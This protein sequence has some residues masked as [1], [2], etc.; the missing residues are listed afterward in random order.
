MCKK[1]KRTLWNLLTVA[2]TTG[3]TAGYWRWRRLDLLCCRSLKTDLVNNV[4]LKLLK[5]NNKNWFNYIVCV[6][7]QSS[8]VVLNTGNKMT[9]ASL[10]VYWYIWNVLVF[11]CWE[12]LSLVCVQRTEINIFHLIFTA[13]SLFKCIQHLC[14]VIE[15]IL[16][17]NPGKIVLVTELL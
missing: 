12:V 15:Y 5:S 3:I 6:K 7:F 1:K 2:Q 14:V 11:C 17:V 9:V 13:S 4:E 16:T 8:T 10:S